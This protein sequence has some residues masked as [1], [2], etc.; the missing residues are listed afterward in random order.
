M[1]W[2]KVATREGVDL[3][4][5]SDVD[6]IFYDYMW[7]MTGKKEELL[8]TVLNNKTF[9]HYFKLDFQELGRYLYKRFLNNK[10]QIIKYYED[11]EG[12]LEEIREVTGNFEKELG[13]DSNKLKLLK[14][15][16]T[17]REQFRIINY[18][19]SIMPFIAIEAWQNDFEKFISDLIKKRGLEEK[20][21]EIL[22][23]VYN[24]WKK[25]ALIEIQEKLKQ[26]VDVDQL[27]EEYQFLRSWSIIWYKSITKEWI[28][29]LGV[30]DD[31]KGDILSMDEVVNLL[32]PEN[33][34][35]FRIA[36][37]M[38]FFKDWRDDLRRKHIYQWNFFF[39]LIAKRL[40]VDY[41]CLAYLT[42]DEIRDCLDGEVVDL[43]LINNRK[44]GV[45][46]TV[47]GKNLKMK[48]LD[49]IPDKYN[50][51]INSIKVCSSCVDINGL[52]AYKGKVRGK[53][54][55]VKSYHDIKKVEH[56]D[57]LV[58]NTTHPN[59]LPAMH[60]AA[61]FVTDEGGIASHAAIVAREM[62]KPCIVATKNASKV[63]N[64]GDFVEVDADN[65]IVR[66]VE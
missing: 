35:F 24:P 16:D 33:E 40:G 14:A 37:Y 52:V 57:I 32:K 47:D 20:Q 1:K 5:V 58:A 51:V 4:T 62:K 23:A 31:N 49:G 44:K 55:I 27:L 43:E 15:F 38:I 21:D 50:E 59:Y 7:Q 10:D 53:V 8:F 26:G 64:I 2:K 11:G 63:L 22:R 34:S 41:D 19:Y 12:L 66:K 65:G 56:G 61:A 30:V 36:P 13:I 17:F 48:V 9:T 42:L 6:V 46:I 25:T 39:E 45:I 28:E 29:S 60:K 18:N 54:V 3:P